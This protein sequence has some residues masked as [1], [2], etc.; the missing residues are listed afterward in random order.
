M[1]P[2]TLHGKPRIRGTRIAVTMILE[3]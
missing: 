1:E 2:H 3:L